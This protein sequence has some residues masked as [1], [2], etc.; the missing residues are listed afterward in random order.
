M[1]QHVVGAGQN[2]R[3]SS[4]VQQQQQS[5]AYCISGGSGRFDAAQES[6]HSTA[7]SGSERPSEEWH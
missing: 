1:R 4:N 2:R 6:H 3:H 7:L 5:R